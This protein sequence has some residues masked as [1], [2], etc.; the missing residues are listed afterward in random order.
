MT[1]R[2]PIKEIARQSGLGTA[3]VDRVIN[4]RA[5]VS[6]QTRARV[7]AAM[8]ELEAQ[9]QQLSARGRRLFVDVVVEAPRRF[10]GQ[11]RAACEAA[12][13]LSS[14]AVFRPRFL[15][16]EIMTDK[17]IAACLIRIRK[18]GSHGVLL[19]ARDVPVV[20]D[21]VDT[22]ESAGIPVVTL[23]T[24]IAASNRTAY[25]GIDNAKAG[26][27]AAYLLSQVLKA[28]AGTILASRSQEEFRG[29]AERYLHFRDLFLSLCPGYNIVEAVGGAGL[30][31]D[32]IR[33]LNTQL[34]DVP[35]VNAVYSMG[36][37]NRAILEVLEAERKA[38]EEFIAHDLDADNTSL[39]R[40]GRISFVLHHDLKLDMRRAFRAL[41][42]RHGLIT[43]VNPDFLSD[44]QIITP[45]NLPGTGDW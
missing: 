45:H 20:R 3:T 7:Q 40:S 13:H 41:S 33:L 35:A 37:G 19:K 26:R 27:T 8:A 10:S 42:A 16:Q 15:F 6:P 9:E 1:H 14:E 34:E 30:Q 24:D 39:L 28:D 17:E 21:R 29:E 31:G 38:P 23:V 18:R 36:G 44:V 32:T 25:V 5:H 22:L 2:F 43:L 12:L 11:I 4:N